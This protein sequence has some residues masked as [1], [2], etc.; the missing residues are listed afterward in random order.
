[1]EKK[2]FALVARFF[3][4]NEEKAKLWFSVSN[5]QL[6]MISP[7]ELVEM[8]QAEQVLKFVEQCLLENER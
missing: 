1:M 8:G 6:G 2:A 3:G 5:P 7:E 4:G